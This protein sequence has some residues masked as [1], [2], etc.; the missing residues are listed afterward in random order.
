MLAESGLVNGRQNKRGDV[1]YDPGI[2]G[3]YCQG[4]RHG[5]GGWY[6]WLARLLRLLFHRSWGGSDQPNHWGLF[7]GGI[8]FTGWFYALDGQDYATLA[9]AEDAGAPVFAIGRFVM[10]VVNF[11]IIAFVVFMLVKM[12]N[13]IKDASQAPE[14]PKPE[15]PPKARPN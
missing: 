2:Q 8:D 3:L 11:L 12:V 14:T 5:Y 9:A 6:Y 10:A 1:G 13:R 7:T 15:A 4:Q